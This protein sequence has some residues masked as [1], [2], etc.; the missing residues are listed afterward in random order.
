MVKLRLLPHIPRTA[1]QLLP[2]L[3][4]RRHAA[5]ERG[6]PSKADELRRAV[7]ARGGGGS[8]A[9]HPLDFAFF[10]DFYFMQWGRQAVYNGAGRWRWRRR[11]RVGVG[12][13]T[14]AATGAGGFRR[15]RLSPLRP[16]LSPPTTYH[17]CAVEG[18]LLT[19]EGDLDTDELAYQ[20]AQSEEGV[21]G[22]L[23][24]LP[25]G[26]CAAFAIPGF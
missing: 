17:R 24:H 12:L 14:A 16:P 20:L 4:P 2:F 8:W 25:P 19:P 13:V 1:T 3:L 5:A 9:W 23:D 10:P 26:G 21:Q 18:S 22:I 11:W 6:A 7:Q 15:L